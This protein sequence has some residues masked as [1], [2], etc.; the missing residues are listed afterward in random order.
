MTAL[1]LL[2]DPVMNTKRLRVVLEDPDDDQYLMAAIEGRTKFIV[3]GDTHLL[4]IRQYEGGRIVTA[5]A[6]LQYLAD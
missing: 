4:N 6:F 2:A 5:K 1:T 3:T